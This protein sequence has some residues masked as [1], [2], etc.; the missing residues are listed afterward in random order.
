MY[1]KEQKCP[2]CGHIVDDAQAEWEE[3]ENQ[4]DCDRCKKVYYVS[5]QY[6]FEGFS[7]AKACKECGEIEDECC[8][9]L[10]LD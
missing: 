4:V 8:C 5:P 7:I 2:Y 9:K 1:P 6:R 10:D 3:G